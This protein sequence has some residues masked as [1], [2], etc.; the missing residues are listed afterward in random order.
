MRR[1]L[2][3]KFGRLLKGAA[4]VTWANELLRAHAARFC[5]RPLIVPTVVDTDQWR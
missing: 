4:E 3:G 2:C 5:K 1:L